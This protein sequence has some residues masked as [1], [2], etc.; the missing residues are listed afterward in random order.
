MLHEFLTSNRVEL[1]RRCREKEASR[2]EPSKVPDAIDHGVPLFMQQLT[3][4]LRLEQQTSKR[5][6]AG[7]DSAPAQ[8][9]IGRAATLH[10]AEMLRL[11][12]SVDQVVRAYGDVCQSVTEMAVEQKAVISADEFRTLNRCLDDAIADAVTSHGR[13]HQVTLNEGADTLYNSMKKFSDEQKRLIDIAIQ[14]YSAIK[15][16]NIG[17]TGATGTLLIQCLKDLSVLAEY[18]V[19]E[20]LLASATATLAPH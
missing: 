13:A 14:A 7:A 8:S 17:L 15:T 6:V 20:I 3:D 5:A 9:E 19:P 12:F 4:T 1:V 16:G 2:F 11:G 10:G 18:T